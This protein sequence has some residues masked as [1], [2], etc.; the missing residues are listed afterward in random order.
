MGNSA[1]T[2]PHSRDLNDKVDSADNL[3]SDRF[4]CQIDPRHA[5]HV[6]HTGSRLL[7]VVGMKCAHGSIVTCV[8]RLEH[9]QGLSAPDFTADDSVGAHA[10]CILDK[11][12]H[13][14]L[15]SAL[16]IGRACFKPDDMRLLEL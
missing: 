12:A 8:H 6:L 3:G 4:A 2:I 15:A 13:G 5:D 9:V 16:E 10:Q 14:N 11:V 7:V 1:D